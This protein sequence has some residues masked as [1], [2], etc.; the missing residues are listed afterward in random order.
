[1]KSLFFAVTY[2]I[3]LGAALFHGLYGLRNILLELNPGRRLRRTINLGL[4][5]VGLAL[6]AFGT[7]AALA[8]ARRG[9]DGG[10]L[11]WPTRCA[12]QVVFRV[13][14]F[15]P[16]KDRAPHW[17]DSPHRGRARHDR[18]RRPVEDQG[19][20]R[21][22]PGLALLVPHGHLRLVRD[23]DQR[24]AAAGLQHPDRRARQRRR[25]RRRRC[26]TST[27][28]RTW[29]RTCARCSRPTASCCP[30]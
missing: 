2:V 25:R 30:T 21:P 18:A 29:S 3:L 28:S 5:A 14:R 17:E 22:E 20:A 24:P 11:T 16:G 13:R 4:S 26:P 7:W 10:R 12:R 15:E 1:M 8:S 6:F 19:A 27:S 23:A 9:D